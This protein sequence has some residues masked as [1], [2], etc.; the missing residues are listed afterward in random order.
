MEIKNV[1]TEE[2]LSERL[3][4]LRMNNWKIDNIAKTLNGSTAKEIIDNWQLPTRD[5]FLKL[6]NIKE[7]EEFKTVYHNLN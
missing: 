2:E 4:K 3:S 6:M 1:L 5:M 7:N